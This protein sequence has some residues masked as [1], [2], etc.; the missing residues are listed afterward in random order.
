MPGKWTLRRYEALTDAPLWDS[1]VDASRNATFLHRR[2]YMDYHASRFTDYS[3][4]A[5][6]DGKPLALLPANIDSDALCSHGGLTYGGWLLPRHKVNAN[7]MGPLMEA[8]CSYCRSLGLRAVDY[9]PV[10]YIYASFPAQEDVYWLWRAGAVMTE[11]NLATVIDLDAN[12]GFNSAQR[13]KLR[14]GSATGATVCELKGEA[15][16]EEFHSML[17][18]CLHDRHEAVPVHSVAELKL[19][20]SR[21]P[22]Q[23]R[24]HAM[25]L[26]GEIHAGVCSYDTGRVRHL[27]YIATTAEGRRLDLLTPLMEALIGS[28]PSGTRYFDFGTSNEDHGHYLNPGLL[29]QK[30][31]LG[32]SGVA[33]PRYRLTL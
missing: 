31:E 17:A 8:L 12:P 18:G 21:F 30:W 11:C 5:E 1:L 25:L 15:E 4:I 33:Y 6:L 7:E 19:L 16:I 14:K 23:I 2:A 26:R 32:G 10:P 29:R 20:R 13:R 27:Q 3:I 22:E 28:V 9:K 24:I